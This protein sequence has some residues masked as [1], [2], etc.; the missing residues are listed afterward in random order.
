M[1]VNVGCGFKS[2]KRL[3]LFYDIFICIIKLLVW[4]LY[5]NDFNI[6]FNMLWCFSIFDFVVVVFGVVFL[7]VN[8][9]S[10]FLNLNVVLI[11]CFSYLGVFFKV[12][13][14]NSKIRILSW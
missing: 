6:K 3:W 2:N 13:I 11:G 12:R 4:V 10:F 5:L 14:N 8:D 1:W 7:G 9:I